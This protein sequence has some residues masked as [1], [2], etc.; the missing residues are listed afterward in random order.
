MAFRAATLTEKARRGNSVVLRVV[1]W[2]EPLGIAASEPG[3]DGEVGLPVL[4]ALVVGATF[5]SRHAF[6]FDFVLPG[7]LNAPA[8]Q[9]I[10]KASEHAPESTEPPPKRSAQR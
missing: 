5:G 7:S 3:L 6:A 8:R 2:R 1:V 9:S 4:E 10:P